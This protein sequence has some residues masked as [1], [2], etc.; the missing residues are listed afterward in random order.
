M[1]AERV[2]VLGGGLQ[3]VCVALALEASGRSVTLLEAAPGCLQRASLR[4]EGKI[5]LGFVYANDPSFRTPRLMLEAALAFGPLL[6]RWMGRAIDW[7]ALC[8]RRFT[9]LLMADSLVSSD[10]LLASWYRLDSHYRSEMRDSGRCYL[11]RRLDTLLQTA[12]E[13]LGGVIRPDRVTGAIATEETAIDPEAFGTLLMRRLTRR[14]AIDVR[15]HHRV[16]SIERASGGFRVRAV[17][18]E[19]EV[20]FEADTVVNCL[21]N[22]RLA[23]DAQLGLAPHRGWVYRLKHRLL[24][25][26]PRSLWSLPSLTLVLGRYGDVVMRP[27]GQTYLSWYPTCMTG[28][29]TDLESPAA[30]AAACAGDVDTQ[31]R[32]RLVRDGLAALDAIVPGLAACDV[33]TVDAGII[34]SWGRTDIDDPHSELHRRDSIGILSADG[35][36]SINTGKLTCAPLFAQQLVELLGA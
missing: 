8:S 2:L 17:V 27:G 4:N 31:E 26:A 15:N 29:S 3:G 9:Y 23:I 10:S 7:E 32:A 18:A 1:T 34:F 20:L 35:Y 36:F 28:W 13:G 24:G 30:W 25:T 22:G 5:H 12:P 14:A 21:W 33:E 16:S 11:G 19:R 6:E